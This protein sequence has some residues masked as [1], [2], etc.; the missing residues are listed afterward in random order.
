MLFVRNL[1]DSG[2]WSLEACLRPAQKRGSESSVPVEQLSETSQA[3]A[4]RGF[5]P[6]SESPGKTRFSSDHAALARFRTYTR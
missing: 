4:V 3:A 6:E 5:I 2:P 1:E